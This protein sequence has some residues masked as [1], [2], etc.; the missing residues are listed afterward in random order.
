M[1]GA[2]ERIDGITQQNAALVEESAAAAE[3]LRDQAG[4]MH[5]LVGAFRIARDAVHGSRSTAA[6]FEAKQA[7]TA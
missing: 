4:Q 7:G 2:L 6:R 3:S 5:G 1:R